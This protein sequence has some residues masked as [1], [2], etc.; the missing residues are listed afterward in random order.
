MSAANVF[1]TYL[2][3]DGAIVIPILTKRSVVYFFFT[4]SQMLMLALQAKVLYIF[5]LTPSLW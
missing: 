5:F 1:P 2:E 4:I 3:C